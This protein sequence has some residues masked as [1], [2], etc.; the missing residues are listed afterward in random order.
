MEKSKKV[1]GIM[2][3]ASTLINDVNSKSTW[4]GKRIAGPGR[5]VGNPG[6]QRVAPEN[7]KKAFSTRLDPALL[8]RLRDYC[9][10]NGL[11]QAWIIQQAIS[12]FLMNNE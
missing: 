4:G 3:E 8:T 1:A 9:R 10:A 11:K 5:K 6:T 12:D 7:C 2:A